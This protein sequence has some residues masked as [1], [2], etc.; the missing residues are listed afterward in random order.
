[1]SAEQ[2]LDTTWSRGAAF[3]LP[4]VSRC[5]QYTLTCTASAESHWLD[6]TASLKTAIIDC[7]KM[8]ALVVVVARGT[9]CQVIEFG[10]TKRTQPTV[11]KYAF[12]ESVCCVG[13][14]SFGDSYVACVI[15][16]KES[17]MID[18]GGQVTFIGN[19]PLKVVTMGKLDDPVV[20]GSAEVGYLTKT[21]IGSDADTVVKKAY[22]SNI[23]Q[24]Q[25]NHTGSVLA[26][27]LV[28]GSISFVAEESLEVLNTYS[29][30]YGTI[31]AIAWN[32][33][34]S[35][36]AFAGQDD[37]L[38][39]MNMEGSVVASLAG[40]TSFITSIAFEIMPCEAK[41]HV[42]IFTSAEDAN[43][44]C[45]DTIGAEWNHRLF[46]PFPHPIRHVAC[47]KQFVVVI[48]SRAYV[49]LYQRRKT[50]PKNP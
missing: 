39:L 18:S 7:R 1:M 29:L 33:S 5:A 48:D 47:F 9:K 26:C 43:L 30:R 24:M 2:N 15:L 8:S 23:C 12:K 14:L 11:K 46:G 32:R 6:G 16:G 4:K 42:R 35:L 22:E 13:A 28:N 45:F 49:S 38:Y 37:N 41:D 40:H 3:D 25:L 31:R 36:I 50:K 19:V 34:D 27:G 21:L 20:Y 10:Y 44:G 17:Y